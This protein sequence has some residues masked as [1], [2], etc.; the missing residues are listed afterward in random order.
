MALIG[1]CTQTTYTPHPT[2]VV[3][4]TVTHPDGTVET[5]QTPEQV[6]TVTNYT[7]VYLSVKQVEIFTFFDNNIKYLIVNYQYAAYSSSATR[8]ANQENFLFWNTGQLNTHNHETNLY[9]Q[10][11]T[12]ISNIAGLGN[13]IAD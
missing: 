11:Y 6:V 13:L 1:N 5:I 2:N 7:N 4:E 3:S 9:D 12:E 8:N 10:I